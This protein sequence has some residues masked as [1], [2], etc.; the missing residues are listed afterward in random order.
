MK[1]LKHIFS[2][3]IWSLVALYAITMA[4]I[5]MPFV[6]TS[7]AGQ[8][9]QVLSEKLGTTV[10]VGRVDLGFLNRIIIDDVLIRDQQQ[11]DML[12]VGRLS[13]KIELA[14]LAQGRISISSAQLFGAHAHL[15]RQDAQSPMN[16]QFV[17][18]SL[19]SKD[20]TSHTPLDLH[21]GSFIMRHSSISYDEHD[22]A[23]RHDRLDTHHLKAT[24]ISAHIILKALKD[25]SL[26][27]NVKRLALKEQSGLSINHLA[28]KF[29]AGEHGALME[30]MA[31]RLPESTLLSDSICATYDAARWKETLRFKGNLR[32]TG[33]ALRDLAILL[34]NLKA[35]G[36]VL[37]LEAQAE[38]TGSDVTV[39]RLLIGSKS[40]D[41]GLEARGWVRS[42]GK[43]PFW[44]AEVARLT[45]SEQAM[46]AVKG[47]IDGVPD[48]VER[49]GTLN[50][51][52]SFTGHQNGDITLFSHLT[53]GVGDL[54]LQGMVMPDRTF[55][56]H[57]ETQGIDLQQLLQSDDFGQIATRIDVSG[58]RSAVN[59]NGEIS[60]LAYKGYDYQQIEVNGS[61]Q[62]ASAPNNG[63]RAEGKLKINDPNIQTDVEGLLNRDHQGTAI[64]LT[65]FINQLSPQSLHLSDQ[66][67]DAVFSAIVDAD[68]TASNLNDAQGSI[69]LDD[70]TM[71]DSLGTFQLENIHLKSGYED[72]KHYLR[73]SGDMGEAVLRGHFDWE[74]LPQSF[75]NYVASKL[76][77]LPGLPAKRKST[78]NDFDLDLQLQ[79][80]EWLSRIFSIPISLERPLRLQASINDLTHQFSINGQLPAFTY[81]GS[82]YRNAQIDLSSPADTTKCRISLT[83]VSE[84]GTN[85]D[86]A[87]DA[88]ASDN[89]LFLN[90]TWDNHNPPNG[91]AFRGALNTISQLYANE[92]GKPEAHVRIMPSAAIVD[93]TAWSIEPG[94]IIYSD[95]H[96]LIDHLSVEHGKQH[97]TVNGVASNHQSDTLKVELSEIDVAY[98]LDIVG[99]DAVDF[100]GKASGL[101]YLTQL[102][103][104]PE[105]WGKL[106]VD[107]FLFEHGRMGTLFANVEWNKEEGQIDIDATADDGPEVKTLINGYVSPRRDFIDLDIEGQGTNIEFIHSFTSSFLS[108]PSGQAF[109]NLKLSGPLSYINLTGQLAVN[110]QA[111]VTA[112]GTTYQLRGDTVRFIPNDI[113]L[114][115]LP[116]Y[117]RMGN[118][119]YIS[120][121]LHHQHLT[122]MTFDLDVTTDRLL[123]YEFHDFG[124]EIFYGTVIASGRVDLH[125]RPG[126]VTI[127]C[128]VTPLPQTI[129]TYNAASTDAISQQE[130]I[131]WREAKSEE[132]RREKGEF[133][134]A[135]QALSQDI[136]DDSPST[137]IYLNFLINATPEAEMRL[138]MDERTADYITLHGNG[139]IRASYHDKGAFHMFGTYVVDNGTYG[140]TIQNIIKKNFLFQQG[141]TI[142]FGGNPMDAALNL[143]AVYTVNGVSLSDLSIGNSFNNTVRVNCLMNILGQAGAPRVEFDLDMP[144]VN[145]EEKQMIRSLIASEQEMNQQVLYLLGIGR[146]YTQGANNANTDQEYGQTQ[147]AMQSFLSGTLSTQINEVISQVINTGNWNFGAN[148]STGNEGW[149]NA[150]YEGLVSGRMLNNR[151][152]INGQFGYRD[153][154]TQAN[155][156]FIGDFDIRYL[157]YPNGNLALKVYNQTNDRYFTHSSLNT[158]GI[159]LI[160]KRDF[161]GL[162]DLLRPRK[163]KKKK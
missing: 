69:D 16:F 134:T 162:S 4:A 52:G 61:Y 104:E 18:D 9:A 158:Q 129:F 114:D 6:Q 85:T 161:N 143:Q 122:R 1:V 22:H 58:N 108:Q 68:L 136:P 54:S 131:T 102:F 75:V 96:L 137:N 95:Q 5:R 35:S 140:V 101:A 20:T 72:Q 117:D 12:R 57:I 116:V 126:E 121:G 77:T 120:G 26:N 19:A 17:I 38:G 40:G 144:N 83:K 23:P 156:S 70:F 93:G 87:I 76:P 2:W 142:T 82:S 45:L 42:L 15:Y 147:L 63:L 111:T 28:F 86:L 155:P 29:A 94:D 160:V 43:Q 84:E 78:A 125:G 110:G 24:D 67:G 109:G 88:S 119:A 50:L 150:E 153:N 115:S 80:T 132:D 56:S 10:S 30:E 49:V 64:R 32:S 91:S 154:A 135:T 27:V 66:W 71:T 106:Q 62:P 21:I 74:T 33:I 60:K 139:V 34:P 41:L 36:E 145:S 159:G 3:T 39:P 46:E 53:T 148:I 103:G 51:T 13:A 31:L 11:K 55:S 163:K 97:L 98:V 37:T 44:Q 8:V 118:V 141:G 73:L 133:T 105:A 7:I 130:F 79:S 146:F 25:D 113:L 123:G 138:L 90:L 65:G 112:L 107:D 59:L 99:F 149:R 127:N 81:Q 92:Q 14:P 151:L 47:S 152:L 89:N 157:L 124:D 128:N 100:D 48:I